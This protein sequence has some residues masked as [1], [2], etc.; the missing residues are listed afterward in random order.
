MKTRSLLAADGEVRFGKGRRGGALAAL[1]R[2][3][4]RLPVLGD[5]MSP[6][7]K[8]SRRTR[9]DEWGGLSSFFACS[10]D[11]IHIPVGPWT[12]CSTTSKPETPTTTCDIFPTSN[13]S[14]NPNPGH[15][16]GT[17]V[18][19]VYKRPANPDCA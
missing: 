2:K 16:L 1:G 14:E 8:K 18:K 7:P 5:F 17:V 9:D 19:I 4:F 15:K 12:I 11:T 10:V 6:G 3:R 13:N